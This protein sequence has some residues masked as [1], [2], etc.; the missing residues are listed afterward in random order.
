RRRNK[1]VAKKLAAG[2][3]GEGVGFGSDEA[4]AVAMHM[5]LADDQVLRRRGGRQSPALFADGDQLF[6][7]GHVAEELL[8]RTAVFAA[9]PEIVQDLLVSGNVARLLRNVV[10]DFLFSDHDVP[11]VQF[12]N[13]VIW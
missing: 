7:A 3:R 6:T 12:G 2:A 11:K 1:D 4:V 13:L 5:Q 10:K 8:D 9:D